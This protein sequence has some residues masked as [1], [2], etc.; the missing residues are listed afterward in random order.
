MEYLQTDVLIIGGGPAGSIVGK[1]LSIAGI[2]NIIVEKNLNF[3][4]PCGGGIRETAF[5]IFDI[6]DSLVKVKINDFTLVS[7]DGNRININLPKDHRIF[8]VDRKEFDSFLREE[9]KNSGTK[10]IQGKFLNFT[11][12]KK[13]I[14]SK[15]KLD[16]TVITIESNYLVIA[17]GVNFYKKSKIL[18]L[19]TYNPSLKIKNLQFFYG[20]KFSKNFY[21]WIFNHGDKIQIGTVGN[22]THISNICDEAGIETNEKIKGYFIPLWKKNKLSYD[23][24][25][26]FVGDAAGQVLPFTF[27][28]IYFAMSSAKILA[29]CI[30]NNSPESYQLEWE[31]KFLNYFNFMKLLEIIFL[32]NN[33]AIKKLVNAQRNLNIQ[34]RAIDYWTG[35]KIPKKN[36]NT[37]LS[38]FKFFLKTIFNQN[39]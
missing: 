26:F 29:D 9:A 17:S 13:R 24:K 31:R 6:P 23:N 25:I 32:K 14:F 7:P 30:I 8:I 28:G 35:K 27:E 34:K 3:K 36:I 15:I 38:A 20:K 10:I 11:K 5:K 4:K 12:D 16:N 33:F 37:L 18:T 2:E 22:K 19:F 21:G 1:Y 39:I